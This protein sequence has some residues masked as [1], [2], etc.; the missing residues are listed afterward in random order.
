[1]HTK[2]GNDIVI[3]I[4][5]T[6]NEVC[7]KRMGQTWLTVSMMMMVL[8]PCNNSYMLQVVPGN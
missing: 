5:L 3:H 6:K 1:M 4:L 7:D 8:P 2:R